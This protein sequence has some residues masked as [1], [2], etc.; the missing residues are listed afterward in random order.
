M[1]SAL[2]A[3]PEYRYPQFLFL[4]AENPDLSPFYRSL[5]I[6]TSEGLSG[7]RITSAGGYP[8]L[9]ALRRLLPGEGVRNVKDSMFFA[10]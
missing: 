9:R 6:L 7:R 4:D 3:F 8:K 1:C 10:W 2:L 5:V